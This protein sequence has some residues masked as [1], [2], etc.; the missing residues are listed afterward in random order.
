MTVDKQHTALALGSDTLDVLA[1][2]TMIALMENAAM[3]TIVPSLEPGM[4][5]VGVAIQVEHTRASPIGDKVH[6]T[7]RMTRRDGKQCHFDITAF[8]ERGEIG[9]GTHVRC[10][11]D[12]E[13][14]MARVK[15]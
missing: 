14:F 10:I 4:D 12:R 8:D 1:T 9:K 6:A 15:G 13:R 5:S 7:A 2:P 3:Q 11:I